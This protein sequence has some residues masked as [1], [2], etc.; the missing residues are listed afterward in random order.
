MPAKDEAQNPEESQSVPNEE[1]ELDQDELISK[2]VSDP[3]LPP[4]VDVLVGFLGRSSR[5]GYLHLYLN[6]RLN[7]YIDIH[8]QDAHRMGFGPRCH[9]GC[10]TT[11]CPPLLQAWDAP[12]RWEKSP[13]CA[14]SPARTITPCASPTTISLDPRWT[15]PTLRGE[16]GAR[17]PETPVDVPLRA[18]AS[19][20]MSA[21]VGSSAAVAARMGR[22][23][24]APVSGQQGAEL[25][26]APP[27]HRGMPCP[28]IPSRRRALQPSAG[29]GAQRRAR[30]SAR[31]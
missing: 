28:P 7:N 17:Y 6:L 26:G 16:K 24:R 15:D 10:V 29:A 19:L 11:A 8:K 14:G 5:A 20:P 23:P 30:E 27:P 1:N 21:S 3:T 31:A 13:T 12:R 22:A 25:G 18:V 2:L 9:L 4:D